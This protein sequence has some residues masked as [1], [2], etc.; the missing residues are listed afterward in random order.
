MILYSSFDAWEFRWSA[1]ARG[2]GTPLEFRTSEQAL[3]WLLRLQST[4]LAFALSLRNLLAR[5]APAHLT[6]LSDHEVLLEVAQLL[7]VR[8]LFVRRREERIEGGQMRQAGAEPKSAVPF[9][10]PKRRPSYN[11]FRDP[12]P[13]DPATFPAR[14][15]SRPLAAALLAAADSGVPFCPE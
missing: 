9:P 4:N 3:S 6:V 13:E 5:G 14:L 12:E 10:L 2:D 8:R 1:G 15:D 7:R 11:P